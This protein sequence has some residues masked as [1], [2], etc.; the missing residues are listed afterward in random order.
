[1]KR[2]SVLLIACANVANLFLV[3]AE[4]RQR[5][6]VGDRVVEDARAVGHGLGAVH[7]LP[8]RERSRALHVAELAAIGAGI[9]A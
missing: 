7:M 1:M 6:P 9:H 3:R 2:L 4:G 8:R 5:K